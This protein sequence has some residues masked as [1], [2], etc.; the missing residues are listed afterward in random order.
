[1][2]NKANIILDK[3]NSIMQQPYDESVIRKKAANITKEFKANFGDVIIVEERIEN[4]EHKPP[5]QVSWHFKT[6]AGVPIKT[7]IT[8]DLLI[9]LRKPSKKL[10]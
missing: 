2:K 9:Q 3:P 1:M 6:L 10:K 4:N 8:Q 5:F 7:K